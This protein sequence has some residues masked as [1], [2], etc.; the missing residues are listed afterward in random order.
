MS[1]LP[2]TSVRNTIG[3][4]YLQSRED[5]GMQSLAQD[6]MNLMTSAIQLFAMGSSATRVV[7]TKG[8]KGLA[9]KDNLQHIMDA[10]SGG[11]GTVAYEI[12]HRDPKIDLSDLDIQ[13]YSKPPQPQ[14]ENIVVPDQSGP[15]I[16]DTPAGSIVSTET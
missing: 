6:T 1:I 3:A 8:F 14:G 5:E 7:V 13:M 4:Q 15:L 12:F 9:D 16:V 2:S 10:S 11:L